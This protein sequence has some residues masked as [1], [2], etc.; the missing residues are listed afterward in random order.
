MGMSASQVRFLSLQNRKNSIGRQLMTLSN[1]KMALSRD[2]NAVALK[3]TNALNKTVLK[4]SNDSG[5]TYQELS[6]DL[7]MK[8]NDYNASVPYIVSTRDGKVVVD[9]VA[10]LVGRDELGNYDILPNSRTTGDEMTYEYFA[11]KITGAK[12]LD[13]TT[14][15]IYTT[16][17]GM[18]A[19]TAN[20]NSYIIP[21][22]P[23]DYG[24]EHTLRYQIF[25]ELGLVNETTT[26]D[27]T[28]LLTELYGTDNAKKYVGGYNGL[29]S[30]FDI[31]KK[32]DVLGDGTTYDTI[33][34]ELEFNG[35]ALDLDG[36]C[37][38]GN[39][40]LAKAYQRE[41]QNYLNTDITHD[42]LTDTKYTL[43]DTSITDT[44]WL[45]KTASFSN[46][47]YEFNEDDQTGISFRI[48]DLLAKTEPSSIVNEGNTFKLNS[49]GILS[50]LGFYTADGSEVDNFGSAFSFTGDAHLMYD[51]D[52]S[53]Q[54]D[55]ET[56][57]SSITNW[58]ILFDSNGSYDSNT[59]GDRK[60][61]YD[62]DG[63]GYF[64]GSDYINTDKNNNTGYVLKTYHHMDGGASLRDNPSLCNFK[65][66]LESFAASFK[67]VDNVNLDAVEYAKNKTYEMYTTL[68]IRNENHNGTTNKGRAMN[69][70]TAVCDTVFGLG[71]CNRFGSNKDGAAISIPN[72]L[73]VFMTLYQMYASTGDSSRIKSTTTP[74][75]K[76]SV[77]S[78]ASSFDN[79]I[80]DDLNA[81][82]NPLIKNFNE[83]KN[84]SPTTTRI[85]GTTPAASTTPQTI[86]FEQEVRDTDDDGN[87]IT[88]KCNAEVTGIW[89]GSSFTSISNIKYT[90]ND[91]GTDKLERTYSY[92]ESTKSVTQK[93]YKDGT[94]FAQIDYKK[95]TDGKITL[96]STTEGVNYLIISKDGRHPIKG[97]NSNDTISDSFYANSNEIF[98]SD[99]DNVSAQDP[100]NLYQIVFE[101]PQE[102]TFAA[103][104][105][106]KP[107]D[108]YS[109]M[110][111]DLVDRC[112]KRVDDLLFDLENFF[113]G[114]ESKLMDFYDAMF[115]RIAENNSK[116]Y[117]VA[118][119][120]CSSG[121]CWRKGTCSS[122]RECCRLFENSYVG[123]FTI[124]AIV[125]LP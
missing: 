38:Y 66:I 34:G 23:M 84:E 50:H 123:S 97:I 68:G 45:D 124:V 29:L 32:A 42:V 41:Y 82:R 8:P 5:S 104:I 101:S 110:L 15:Q 96:A 16:T 111:D 63:D 94:D 46:S 33:F 122:K 69:R 83:W 12:S 60:G 21:D 28:A 92:N 125:R 30:A 48:I 51:G 4:W 105:K 114:K 19:G 61:S 75:I 53:G 49:E 107:A 77:A 87:E 113:S 67:T 81:G 106:T 7:M 102:S 72:I 64:N 2:M 108:K 98:V 71:W 14:G 59:T 58:G 39:L 9:N 11:K 44:N 10:T 90:Y 76:H 20:K 95:D 73:N 88:R 85:V 118:K 89:N 79:N 99:P 37:A 43:C 120:S 112:Q 47:P 62:T 1:R 55:N 56:P 3:Y 78:L 100:D 86:K 17:D 40:E 18:L 115:E 35:S 54:F 70:A 6:Y 74:A 109:K 26:R 103:T 36:G 25:E 22:G 119:R 80:Q 52:N 116:C 93:S 24:F 65:E 121:E 91:E 57:A 117:C 13:G 31:N 27:Y